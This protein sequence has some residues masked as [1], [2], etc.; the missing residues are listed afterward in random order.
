MKEEMLI[1]KKYGKITFS[2]INEKE[3][4]KYFGFSK[5]K[6]NPYYRTLP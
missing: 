5:S 2:T 4:Q 6:K 1:S 3:T